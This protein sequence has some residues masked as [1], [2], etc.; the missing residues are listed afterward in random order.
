MLR[1]G[2]SINIKIQQEIEGKYDDTKAIKPREN[3]VR[4]DFLQIPIDSELSFVDD[5]S[6]KCIVKDDI[7]KIEYMGEVYSVSRLALKLKREV[8]KNWTTG[9]GIL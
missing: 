8:G 2:S 4:F 5:P 6:K 3:R 7:N 1:E 9:R